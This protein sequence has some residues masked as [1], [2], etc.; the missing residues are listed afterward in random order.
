[1][2]S[3]RILLQQ[4]WD[5]YL[6]STEKLANSAQNRKSVKAIVAALRLHSWRLLQVQLRFWQFHPVWT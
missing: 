3:S 5:S 4:D 1:M 6:G 2:R